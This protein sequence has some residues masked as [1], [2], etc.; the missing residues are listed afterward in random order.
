LTIEEIQALYNNDNGT[1]D[2]LNEWYQFPAQEN[3]DMG[4][5]KITNAAQPDASADS[6]VATVKHV[7][8]S[9]GGIARNIKDDGAVEGQDSTSAINTA[10][11]NYDIVF[12][13]ATSS[14]PFM[15]NGDQISVP[16]NKTIYGVGDASKLKVMSSGNILTVNSNNNVVIRDVHLDGNDDNYTG[17]SSIKLD[18]AHLV[19]INRVTMVDC[20]TMG[21]WLQNSTKCHVQQCYV[22]GNGTSAIYNNNSTK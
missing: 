5:N 1:R 13:P 20:S 14:S 15:V 18:L 21:V 12:I 9:I 6:D 11:A 16:S 7:N 2:F 4:G 3:V 19:S 8:D 22:K 17:V 10:L